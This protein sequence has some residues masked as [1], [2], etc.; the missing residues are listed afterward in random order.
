MYNGAQHSIA[1]SILTTS[2]VAFI[3]W[4]LAIFAL[5]ALG[6]AIMRITVKRAQISPDFAD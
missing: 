5:I 2:A 4:P 6:I 1:A 3:W